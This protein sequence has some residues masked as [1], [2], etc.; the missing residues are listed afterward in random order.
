[1]SLDL[2]TANVATL[3]VDLDLREVTP[4]IEADAHEIGSHA[5]LLQTIH[6]V[7][8]SGTLAQV[9]ATIIETVVVLVVDFLCIA[10]ACNQTVH[11]PTLG[12]PR[13]ET[14]LAILQRLHLVRVPR[15]MR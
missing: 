13:I 15:P 9:L 1:M 7:L 12:T 3:A 10:G 6:V 4:V 5:F 2:V 14:R 8:R 11:V